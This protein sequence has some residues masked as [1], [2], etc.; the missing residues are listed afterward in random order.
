MSQSLL[1]TE[2]ESQLIKHRHPNQSQ[3]VGSLLQLKKKDHV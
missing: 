1:D 3:P 2:A